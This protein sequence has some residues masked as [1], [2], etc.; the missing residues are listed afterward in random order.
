MNISPGR[1]NIVRSSD[2]TG[3]PEDSTIQSI[4]DANGKAILCTDGGRVEPR[5]ADAIAIASLPD[6]LEAAKSIVDPNST[7][8]E[9]DA[10]EN[11]IH[12]IL[13]ILNEA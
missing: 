11:F 7:K 2:S 12:D 8:A 4:V 13:T 6:L 9:R 10:A 5:E 3:D 1:W